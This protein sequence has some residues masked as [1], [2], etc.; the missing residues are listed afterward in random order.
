ML[1]ILIDSYINVK[2]FVLHV[3]VVQAEKHCLWRCFYILESFIFCTRKSRKKKMNALRE[4]GTRVEIIVV[5]N[6]VINHVVELMT[7]RKL[8]KNVFKIQ[9][10]CV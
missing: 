1:R 3:L 8:E 10:R 5:I 9:S 6:V 2:S 4:V 7:I